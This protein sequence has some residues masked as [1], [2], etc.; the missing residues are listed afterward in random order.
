VQTVYVRS[1]GGGSQQGEVAD[2]TD[3]PM[4]PM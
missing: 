2:G 1:G 3:G 4:G